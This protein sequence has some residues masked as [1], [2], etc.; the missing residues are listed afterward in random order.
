[1]ASNVY[2]TAPINTGCSQI[3]LIEILP[4][5]VN[6]PIYC[7]FRSHTL[8]DSNVQ[9]NALSYTWGDLT[10]QKYSI[11]I[12][13][14]AID[15]KQNLWCFLNQARQRDSRTFIWIDALSIDQSNVKE[16]NHQ[17]ALMREIYSK[18]KLLYF[19]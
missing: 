11:F 18:V 1:M 15:V 17:V 2:T 7:V 6:D 10:S 8:D 14:T 12:N 3:R 19:V 5:Q 4:G 13:N 16:R 9:F